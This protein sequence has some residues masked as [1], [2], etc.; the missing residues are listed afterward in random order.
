[1]NRVTPFVRLAFGLVALTSSILLGLDLFGVVPSDT[2]KIAEDRILLAE[3][4]VTQSTLAVGRNDLVS[5][6]PTLELTVKRDE[7]VLSAALRD[8]RGRLMVATRDHRRIWDPDESGASTATH[9][10]S[11]IYQ[12]GKKWATL[13]LRFVDLEP[14]TVWSAVWSRPLFRL[15]LLLGALSFLSYIFYLRHSLRHLDPSAVIP[16]RVQ[17]AL[18]VMAEGVLL[19]DEKEQIVLANEAACNQLGRKQGAL[20]GT[21]ASSLGWLERG[22]DRKATRLPWIET[23]ED[24]QTRRDVPLELEAKDD[25]IV[26]VVNSSPVLD[27]AG[28][29][30][31]VIATFDD[32]TELERS[33][34]RLQEALVEL[35]KSQDEIRLQNAELE[36]V[37]K[38]DPLTGVANRRAFMDWFDHHFGQ[39]ASSGSG[40]CCVMV[41]IDHFKRVNDGHGH[42]TGDEVIRRMADVMSAEVRSNDLV[43]R[44]GGE[45]FCVILTRADLEIAMR[46]AER[47][48]QKVAAP[49]F[50]AVPVTASFGVSSI[51]F[52]A[53]HPAALIDQ[54]DEALYVSK[55]GGRNRVTS[56]GDVAT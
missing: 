53:M 49:G 42:S 4:L 28:H 38:L 20:I 11:P 3:S 2:E 17:T 33:R 22:T 23:L 10:Q 52:G 31:G 47:L 9:M 8:P 18:D 27:G 25:R 7:N 12:R 13:E 16:P 5:L 26:V 41:D 1:V 40:L 51:A 24:A 36:E 39:A 21:K 50:A 44:Y 34:V 15:V 56:Y 14:A 37:S 55:D 32:V 54:A 43:C 6:R 48:R 46:V 29:A 45:E 30:K 19:L 35:E